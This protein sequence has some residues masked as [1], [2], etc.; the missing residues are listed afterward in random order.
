M[1]LHT[2]R[3]RL[4]PLRVDHAEML[5]DQLQHQQLYEFIPDVPPESVAV[6]RERYAKL[7]ARSSSDGQEIWLN[8]IVWSV[9]EKRYVG[10]V[11]ATVVCDGS[12][13]IAYVF[14][15]DAWGKGYA[16]E[17]VAR[18]IDYLVQTYHDPLLQAYVDL[19]NHRS[20]T[21][22]EDLGFIRLAVNNSETE[23]E[24]RKSNKE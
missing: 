19:R 8:W 13:V 10:Y 1:E 7:A 6:L 5:F 12:V 20:I 2:T 23:A 15:V 3:L 18:M 4:E 22:L 11:Q 24:Y 21:L 16:R 14:F 9:P 17:A